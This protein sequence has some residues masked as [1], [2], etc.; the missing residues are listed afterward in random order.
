M[1][2]KTNGSVNK[3]P[4]PTKEK[5]NDKIDISLPRNHN[6]QFVWFRSEITEEVKALG[7]SFSSNVID[8]GT[9]SR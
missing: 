5:T 7:K 1:S 3:K 9:F 6:F 8:C 2:E 4:P